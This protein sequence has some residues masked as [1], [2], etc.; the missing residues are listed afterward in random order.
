R[1]RA[2]GRAAPL[3]VRGGGGLSDVRGARAECRAPSRVRALSRLVFGPRPVKRDPVRAALDALAA[4]ARKPDDP[5]SVALVR[6]ALSHRSNHVVARAARFV[7]E[8]NLTDLAPHVAGTFARF[9][10]HPVQRDPGC[11]AKTEIVRALVSCSHPAA[12]VYL[13]G[14]RH[15]QREPAFGPP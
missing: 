8:A 9:L 14:A 10:D 12:D 3:A 1:G 13:A 11:V 7:R 2:L 5:G 4:A 6:E 15:V